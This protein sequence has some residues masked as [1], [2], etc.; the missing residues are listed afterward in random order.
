MF[1]NMVSVLQKAR[2]EQPV[3]TF[4]QLGKKER[5]KG[6]KEETCNMPDLQ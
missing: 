4:T 3:L 2:N 6:T 1:L 5:K